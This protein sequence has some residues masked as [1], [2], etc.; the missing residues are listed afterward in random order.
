LKT[1]FFITLS[2]V[3]MLTMANIQVNASTY[4]YI[5]VDNTF[6]NGFVAT[7]CPNSDSV[8]IIGPAGGGSSNWI[9][10]WGHLDNSDT[11]TLAI[12]Y[13]GWIRDSLSISGELFNF[14]ITPLTDTA[15]GVNVSCG[16][17]TM[18]SIRTNYQGSGTLTYSWS[19][20]AGL[21][22][23]N[24]ANP[25]AYPLTQGTTIYTASV[26]VDG[27]TVSDITG[28]SYIP[29][30]TPDICMVGVD[31]ATNKNMII[32]DKP[33]TTLIDSFAIYRET[34]ISGVFAKIGATPYASL[35]VFIDMS[36]N[37]NVQSNEYRISVIDK[38]GFK[39]PLSGIHKTMH[40]SISQGAGNTWNL[41][42]EAYQGFEVLSYQ[43]YRGTNSGNLQ[44]IGSTSGSSTQYSD[45]TAP[46]GNIYYQIKAIN[47]IACNPSKS[48]KFSAS[49]IATN[50]PEGIFE[51]NNATDLF[52]VYPN[53]A[54]DKIILSVFKKSKI[55]ILTAEGETVRTI[56][57]TGPKLTIDLKNLSRGVYLIRAT[58]TDKEFSIK[59][60][61]KQ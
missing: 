13:I 56:D 1:K 55:E 19:P 46:V 8:M 30:E 31:S 50:S 27:C 52:F 34:E 10:D 7:Y 12:G 26:T 11:L 36:S 2:A 61:I 44:L 20:A 57:G 39:M 37:P 29:V 51:N 54:N 49:N 4:S 23:P 41:I 18:I 9:Y 33:F 17:S 28:V 16:D 40:L 3:I 48:Y 5:H 60:L 15:T 42:W 32:W 24:V 21:S 53:P 25:Y 6:T 38:C 59:R 14:M 47:P 43:I 35:S 45:F 22:N 58:T